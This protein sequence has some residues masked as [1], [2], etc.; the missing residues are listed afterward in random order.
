M[1]IN[2]STKHKESWCEGGRF[3]GRVGHRVARI[4]DSIFTVGGVDKD[5]NF[6]NQ[7]HRINCQNNRID[8]LIVENMV[9]IEGFS[10]FCWQDSLYIW[11]GQGL[12]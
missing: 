4:N 5:G 7:V 1:Q 8:T 2:F 3:S 12:G 11:G 6:I 10:M 9:S